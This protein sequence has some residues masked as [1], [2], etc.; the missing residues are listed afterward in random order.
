MSLRKK[1]G[2]HYYTFDTQFH[3]KARAYARAA[4]LRKHGLRARVVKVNELTWE[5]YYREQ[6]Q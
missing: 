6:E 4:A 1:I 2:S 5:V 3:N